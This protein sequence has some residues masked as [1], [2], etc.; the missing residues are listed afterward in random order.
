MKIAIALYDAFTALDAIGPYE[1]LARLPGAEL[2]FAGCEKRIFRTDTGA[3]ALLAT[4]S[5][6]EVDAADVVL[7]PGGPDLRGIATNPELIAWLRKVHP[8]TTWTTSVCTGALALA[9]AG[10]LDGVEA[11]T[12]WAAMEALAE[13]GA[14]PVLERVVVRGKIVTAAGVSA[15]IDMALT[16]AARIAG[17]D[18][19]RALQ[20][21]IEYDPKPPFDSGNVRNA[22]P[23]LV[24]LVRAV[25]TG[26]APPAQ[27]LN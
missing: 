4:A 10:L 9:G 14:K 19:A 3:C 6:A 1:I 16:L 27:T 25:M 26:A 5:F 21:A 18:F 11:V 12:H 8:T 23:E 7:V 20:L 17:E 15:G 24:A 2:V 22:K 13:L